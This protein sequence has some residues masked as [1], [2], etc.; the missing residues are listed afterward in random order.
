MS[1]PILVHWLTRPRPARLPLSTLR[2]VREAVRQK[3]A[4]WRLRDFLV[5]LLR[6]T[7]VLLL[8]LAIARPLMSERSI[9]P[10][11]DAGG[12]TRIVVLDA[13]QS[14][15]AGDHGIQALQRARAVA[16]RWLEFRP[17]LRAN[18]I[19]AAA[20]PQA[21]F[22]QPSA[23]LTSL[24]EELSRA[25][26]RPEALDVQA[27][28]TRASDMLA[29]A[30]GADDGRRELVIVS[31]FQRTN[32]AAADFSVLPKDTRIELESIAPAQPPPN[33]AILRAQCARTSSEPE[34]N[35]EVEV[36]N[37]T[38]TT[39]SV[40]VEVALGSSTH[41]LE[42]VCPAGAKVALMQAIAPHAIGWQSGQA[43]LM[44]VRDALEAD[45]LRPLVSE[46]RRPPT[47]ALIT[48]QPAKQRQSS[49]FVEYALAPPGG[50]QSEPKLVRLDPL[51]VDQD[52]LAPAELIVVD[53]PGKLSPETIKLIDVLVR[54]GRALLYIAAEPVDATNLKLLAS[55]AAGAWQLPVEFMPPA[56]G[57]A[58]R[59]LFVAHSNRQEPP[60]AA[61]GESLPALLAPLRFAGGL[62]SRPLP[63][64]LADDVLVTYNDR[65][66]GLVTGISGA[67]RVAVL[68]AELAASNLPSEH[69][70]VPLVEELVGQLLA[71]DVQRAMTSGQAAFV[72]LPVEA[73][74]VAGLELIGPA[75]DDALGELSDEGAQVMWRMRLTQ[76]GVYEA[77]RDGKPVFAMACVTPAEE[78]E[79]H[80]LAAEV[81]EKRLSGGRQV[82]VH[83]A[84]RDDDRHDDSWVWCLVACLACMIGE[85]GVLKFFRT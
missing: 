14:M 30:P 72:Y 33:L 77:R 8:A 16:A 59:A 64:T 17:G 65:S 40:T 35:L 66:A 63:G 54:R 36:A 80:P 10:A 21:V 69:F 46:V 68:N 56:A 52:A 18:L 19:V 48:R 79:L 13:S 76:P 6:T 39:Q 84:G 22:E 29:T 74:P 67:G 62:A 12:T 45:N 83:A 58:R 11:L 5:L 37:F 34:L 43:R 42:G 15:A 1:L 81:L 31:D 26:V 60:L 73:S 44:G 20:A 75:S 4:R 2:F 41:R 57:Q 49:T 61:F 25:V 82:R 23:N 27:F 9:L 32:W 7:A 28:L 24:R 55:E 51:R 71:R 53:H 3:R 78:S 70:F 38:P 85:A 47:Y 50:G